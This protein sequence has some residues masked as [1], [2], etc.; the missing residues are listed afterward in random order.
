MFSF[1][2]NVALF[3]SSGTRRAGIQRGESIL[4]L[5]AVRG[6]AAWGGRRIQGGSRGLTWCGDF[7]FCEVREQP[8]KPDSHII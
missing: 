4:S 5:A 7:V 2:L 6:A 8:S 3:V 1:L